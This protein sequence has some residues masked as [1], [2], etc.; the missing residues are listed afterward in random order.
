MAHVTD[1]H[2]DTEIERE[3]RTKTGRDIEMSLS[4]DGIATSGSSSTRKAGSIVLAIISVSSAK[5][6]AAVRARWH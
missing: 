5:M 1:V 6:F 2:A 4:G 3:R